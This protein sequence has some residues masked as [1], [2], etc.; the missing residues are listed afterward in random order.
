MNAKHRGVQ[1]YFVGND[2]LLKHLR[3]SFSR[4][5]LCNIV[6]LVNNTVLY[7]RKCVK[8]VDLMLSILN[9]I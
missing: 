5:M 6:P 4:D 1:I 2:E 7:T 9:T 3:E 8:K